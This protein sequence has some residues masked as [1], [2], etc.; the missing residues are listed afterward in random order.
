VILNTGA[1][2][3]L[4]VF[5]STDNGLSWDR[6]YKFAQTDRFS[7]AHLELSEDGR[8][9][10]VTFQD[11]EGALRLQELEYRP[12]LDRWVSR[13]DAKVILGPEETSRLALAN[14]V[15]SADG[16]LYAVSVAASTFFPKINI[17]ESRDNGET[18]ETG[19]MWFPGAELVSARLV[20]TPEVTGTIIATDESLSWL[21]LGDPDARLVEISQH[22]S[23]AVLASHYS[24]TVVAGDIYLA[25]VTTEETPQLE[26]FV[27]EGDEGTWREIEV[28]HTFDAEA[29]V[30]ISSNPDG[31]IYL[32]FDDYGTS[33][34]RVLESLDGGA[35]WSIEAEIDV[36]EGV[37]PGFTRVTAPEYF[38]EDLVVFQMVQPH[39]DSRWYGVSSV[40]VDVDGDGSAAAAIA[41]AEAGSAGM[42]LA[43]PRTETEHEPAPAW[44]DAFAAPAVDDH[45]I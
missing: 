22:G 40:T 6:G 13:D 1:F 33:R 11:E 34:L 31:H 16:G 17:S 38:T 20:S 42:R 2:G 43:A 29:Y 27:Y 7:T 30:Q 21:E 41:A 26:L 28:P 5:S 19:A 4:R 12:F 44:F 45:L 3:G 10:S 35:T 23:F 25:N 36:E 15:E 9:L 39:D 8:G 14:H 18:W 37:F 24:V 32:T